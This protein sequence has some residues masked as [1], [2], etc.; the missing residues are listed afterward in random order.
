MERTNMAC[1]GAETRSTRE[2]PDHMEECRACGMSVAWDL[3]SH[4][5]FGFRAACERRDQQIV[6]AARAAAEEGMTNA[7][8]ERTKITPAGSKA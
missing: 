5:F 7:D 4:P 3:V 1:L 6:A 2:G 8:D